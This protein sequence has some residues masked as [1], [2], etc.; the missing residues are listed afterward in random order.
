MKWFWLQILVYIVDG[1]AANT[2][3]FTSL[4]EKYFF[5]VDAACWFI[6]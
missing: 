3:A 6:V 2:N 5:L 4:Q 1:E